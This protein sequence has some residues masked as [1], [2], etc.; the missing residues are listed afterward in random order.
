MGTSVLISDVISVEKQTFIC[1]SVWL[2]ES[3]GVR[4]RTPLTLKVNKDDEVIVLQVITPPEVKV[5]H[6]V[7][8][9]PR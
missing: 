9:A 4:F 5:L 3:I 8:P 2:C 1:D 6:K 7:P